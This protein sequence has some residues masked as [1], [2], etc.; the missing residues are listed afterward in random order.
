MT[1]Q[2][3]V[4]KITRSEKKVTAALRRIARVSSTDG[5][6]SIPRKRM[7]KNEFHRVRSP[8]AGF[9]DVEL[10]SSLEANAL[11]WAEGTPEIVGICEQPLRIHAAIGNK[12]YYTFDLA[13]IYKSAKEILYEIKDEKE[14]LENENGQKVPKHWREIEYWCENNGRCCKVLTDVELEQHKRLIQNWR[15]LLPHVCRA[16]DDPDPELETDLLNTLMR[17]CAHMSI[18]KLVD[19]YPAVQKE[20][21]YAHI[22]MLLHRGEMQADLIRQRISTQTQLWCN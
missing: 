8:K 12:P 11:F 4:T 17:S 5:P 14:L 20:I 6:F 16:H 2:S 10:E 3:S 19:M 1:S 15:K 21:V 7:V 22:A 18:D 13:L 9:R